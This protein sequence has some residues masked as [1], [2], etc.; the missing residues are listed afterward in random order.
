MRTAARRRARMRARTLR[1]TSRRS[2]YRLWLLL[3]RVDERQPVLRVADDDYLGVLALHELHRRLDA[4]PLEEFLAVALGDD[5]LEVLDAGGFH[6]LALSFLF[7]ALE[8][9]LHSLRFLLRLLLRFDRV[10]QGV[11]KLEVAQE[12]V[13]HDDAARRHLSRHVVQDLLG[14]RLAR[15]GVKRRRGIARG[16]RAHRGAERRLQQYLFIVR[17]NLLVNLRRAPRIEV[18]ENRRLESH[19]QA[20]PRGHGCVLLDLLRLDAQLGHS[21]RRVHEVDPLGER[22]TGHTTED[23]DDA[24]VAGFNAGR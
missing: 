10:L 1:L 8:H 20:L 15:I 4:F 7:F 12:D 11:G 22:A 6:A 3:S 24:D 18:I 23:A 16:D 13:F 14:D 19:D 21:R 2:I 5:V 9:E 17:T